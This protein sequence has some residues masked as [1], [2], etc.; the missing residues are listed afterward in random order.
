VTSLGAKSQFPD[1]T[2]R[3]TDTS[4][5]FQYSVSGVVRHLEFDI[6]GIQWSSEPDR[7][8]GWGLGA[9]IAMGVTYAL[10]LQ[11]VL[12]G[13]WHHRDKRMLLFN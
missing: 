12:T 9:A 6:A 1:V 4:G 13:E 5:K 10:T 3:Y 8:M 2:L 7:T 11:A